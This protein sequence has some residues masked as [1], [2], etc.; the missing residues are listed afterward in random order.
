MKRLLMVF[1]LLLPVVQA[2]LSSDIENASMLVTDFFDDVPRQDVQIIKGSQISVEDTIVFNLIKSNTPDAQGMA[3]YPDTKFDEEKH[4]ILLGSH[5]TNRITKEFD[6]DIDERQRYVFPPM[7]LELGTVQNKKVL[8]IYSQKELANNEN[9]AI[10]RSPLNRFMNE[11]YVPAAATFFSV[12]LLYLWSMFGN[13]VMELANEFI[14]SK[15]IERQDT[16]IKA[17][18]LIN[19]KEVLA[20][21]ITVLVFAVTMSWTWVEHLTDFADMLLLNILIV[22]LITALREGVRLF[23]CHRHKLKS[24]FR[25]WPFGAIATLI[26]T[27]LGNTFSLVSYT[28]L[29]EDAADER[30]FGKL[31]LGIA[32]LTHV[33][34]LA[35]YIINLF[36]PSVVWQLIFVYGVMM[37]FIEFFPMEPFPGSDIRKWNFPVWLIGYIVVF[38]TY[39]FTNFTTYV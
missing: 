34:A 4:L 36:T 26:S 20:I 28:L 15:I 14:S 2:D 1:L 18:E 24:E 11:K 21:I 39:L 27:Y 8:E 9:K 17:H 33:L 37:N 7:V 38:V 12:L 19:R 31:S 6:K 22:G 30:F 5:R 3:I 32:A 29:D 35:A 13:T 25:L 16:G 23:F 10:K